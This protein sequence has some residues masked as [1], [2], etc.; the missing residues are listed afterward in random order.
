[1]GRLAIT[2]TASFLGT[3]IA[4]RLAAERGPTGLV[5]LDVAPNPSE[6]PGVR[7]RDVDLTQPTSDQQLLNAFREEEVETLLHLAFFTDPQRDTTYTHEVES[8]GTLSLLSAAAAAGVRRVVLR[9][10]T[11]VYGAHGR[12]PSFLTERHPLQPNP[13]L[14]WLRDK[15]EAEGHAAGFARRFPEMSVTVL[16]LAP[17]LG[18]EVRTFYTRLL[19]RRLLPVPMGYDPLLQLLHP[20]DALAALMAAL[21]RGPSGPVNVVPRSAITLRT[22]LHLA[23]KLPVAI[24]HPAAYAAAD[25]LWATGLGPAPGG[26]LDYVRFLCVADGEKAREEMGFEA[27]HTSREAL[28]AWLAYRYPKATRGGR[29]A[30]ARA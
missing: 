2:G 3:R 10:F 18:P 26:F 14:A 9:S 5:T 11:A 23:G 12:N 22:L 30:E 27:R 15:V 6:L 20:E 7:H 24:P 8:I 19:E 1:V 17:L 25:L 21:E 28:D 4:R 13:S 16:R 29:T